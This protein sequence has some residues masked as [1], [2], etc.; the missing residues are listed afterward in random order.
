MCSYLAKYDVA[1]QDDPLAGVLLLAG[2]LRSDW[3]PLF[4]ELRADRPVLVSP[5]FTLVT[6]FADVTEVLSRPEVF[7]VRGY[8]PRL[9]SAV[10]GPLMLSRDNS[11]LN[12]REKGLM[13]VMLAPEDVPGIRE[14]AGRWADEA[15]DQ[16]EAD[17]RIEVVGDLFR[18]VAGR[19]CGDYFGF[20]GPDPQ[21]LSRWSRA[22]MTDVT[23]NLHGDPA[24]KAAS[25]A[26]GAEMMDYLRALLM[27]RRAA[28]VAGHTVFD[29]LVRTRLPAELGFDDERLVI[30]V[31]ALML[32]FIENASGSLV[33]LVGQILQRPDVHA[34]AA[35][36]EDFDPYVWEALRFDPFLKMIARVCE[37][38]HLL[39]DGTVVAAGSLVLAATASAMFDDAAVEEPEAFRLDRPSHTHLHFGHGPHACLGVHPGAAVICEVARRLLRRP[40]VRLLDDAI[41]RDRDVF[42]DRF[43]LGLGPSDTKG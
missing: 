34:A 26:A 20:P 21:T 38:D 11:P 43:V 30:N 39:S 17:G 5:G 12:W 18:S 25:A 32:G 14:Q 2:W 10:G 31:A 4:A 23:A 8:A 6:R 36:A 40:G 24:V 35:V 29:R 22:V 41:V 27:E 33:H 42:P 3:R 28:G 1:V 15:L 19:V 13:Q 7:T 9:E 16:A 37:R